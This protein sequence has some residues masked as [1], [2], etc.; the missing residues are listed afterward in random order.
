MGENSLRMK[1]KNDCSENGIRRYLT[2]VYTPQQNGVVERMNRTLLGMARSML[3]FKRLSPTYWAE[4]IHTTVY[5]RNKSPT[6]SLDGITP[7]EAWF[8]FK[9][10]VKH[11][12]VFGS[13]CYALVPKEKR[14]KLDSRSLKCTMIGYSNE[15]KGYRLLT[16]GKF[17]VSRDVIFD[18]T[19]SKSAEEIENL[20][21]KL[22]S[23]GSKRNDKNQSQPTSP[24]WYE[25]D[26]PSSEDESSTSTPSTRSSSSSSE[27]PSSSSSSDSDSPHSSP[28]RCTSVYIN[29]LYNDGDFTEAQTSEHQLPKWVVQLLKDVKP[30]EQNKTVTRRAH[31]SEG[32]FSLIAND[33]TEPSTYKEAEGIDYEETFAPTAKWNTIRLTLALAAQKGWKLH[34]MDV[35]SAFLNGDLQEEVYM[36]QPLGFEV[37]GQEH[38]V[39]KLIKALY[40]LKQAPRAWY[41]KMDEYLKKVG[42]QR[43]ESDDTLYVRQQGKYLVILVMYVDDLIITGNH[44]DHIAQVKKELQAGFKM[45]DLGLLHY[46]LGVEVFQCPRHIFISHSKYAAEVLQRFGMQDCKPVLTP[47]E[48]NLKLS[49]FEG[50]ERWTVQLT[51]S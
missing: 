4:A 46:Y 33:F 10:R 28:E 26:F 50:G 23:K 49:K 6:A 15:K 48:K 43:S 21:H 16:N 42:F 25:L 40:G 37:E 39:C 3:T 12:R 31:I 34:Q 35:K 36:T 41:A 2:N 11:L 22:E 47:M 32:N 13:V 7:Y 14:T 51:G 17:I 27:S 44:D 19:E 30:D 38:K 1:F 29:P 24:N 8:G 45:T 9:P 20:L 5:L 18:E